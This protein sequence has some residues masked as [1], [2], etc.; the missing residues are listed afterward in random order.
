MMESG[1]NAQEISEHFVRLWQKT[2]HTAKWRLMS[3][4]KL[5]RGERAKR[6]TSQRVAR[7]STS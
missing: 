7:A 3:C 5:G 6:L 2:G 4:V 1:S